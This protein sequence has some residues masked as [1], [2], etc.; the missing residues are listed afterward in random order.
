MKFTHFNEAGFAKMVDVS[1]KQ[2]TVRRAVAQ[3]VV[4]MQPE[5]LQ[6]IQKGEG[7]KGDVLGVA[8]VAGVIGA[9]Q[10]WQMIPMCHPLMLSSVD[11]NFQIHEETATILIE[12]EVKTTGKT[13]VEMEAIHAVSVTAM[14]IYDMI[15]AV[16][17]WIEITDI[18]LMEKSGG[19][20]GYVKRE[21][22]SI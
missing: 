3:A 17:R 8:Q 12:S 4:K 21:V 5:T 13:G 20:S 11:I 16:D 14:T 18:K 9:K 2:D 7:K 22:L 1:E 6:M 19:K 15:K 10:T